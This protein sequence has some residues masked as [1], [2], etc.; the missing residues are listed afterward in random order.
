MLKGQKKLFYLTALKEHKGACPLRI[1]ETAV[2]VSS[3]KQPKIR[4]FGCYGNCLKKKRRGAIHADRVWP[5]PKKLWIVGLTA[6]VIHLH[7]EHVPIYLTGRASVY[8]YISNVDGLDI[9]GRFPLQKEQN[10]N[11]KNYY[12]HGLLHRTDLMRAGGL[13]SLFR[14]LLTCLILATELWFWCNCSLNYRSSC[15]S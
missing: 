13:G 2:F 9:L 4:T 10:N 1:E 7:F 3:H 8:Q 12:L 14:L 6:V 15:S 5:G 11:K